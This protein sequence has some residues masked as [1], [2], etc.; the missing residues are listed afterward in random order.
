[1][2]RRAFAALSVAT[3]TA[4][5]LVV[6]PALA[7]P[8]TVPDHMQGYT[9]L[10]PGTDTS[11]AH[12]A[13][14]VAMYAALA[15]DPEVTVDELDD[16]FHSFAFGPD[17]IEREY[18][19]PGRTDVTIYRDSLGV[20]HVYSDSD[21]GAAY[22]LGYVS[23]EDRL[24]QM[25][26]LRHAGLGRLSEFLGASTTTFDRVTRRDTYST[27][28]LTKML[29]RLDDRF[30]PD[31]ALVQEM[32]QAYSDGVNARVAEIDAGAITKPIEY[33]VQRVEPET[34]RP[35]DSLAAAI[36]QIRAF[37][38]GGGQEME[39][40][41]A[42]QAL[43]AALGNDLGRGVFDDLYYRNDPDA[44]TSIPDSVGAFP[45]QDLGPVDAKAVAI[46]D[47]PAKVVDRIRAGRRA[48]ER[49]LTRYGLSS[50]ASHFVAVDPAHSDTGNPLQWGGPQ[51]GYSVPGPFMEIDVHS[52]SID[53][54][55]MAL[56][57]PRSS[58]RSAA[59]R[60]ERGL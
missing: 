58:R 53:S 20:P 26:V 44:P 8:P 25:D 13:D 46:P 42:L 10:P 4:A 52:P 41:A 17:T 14:Q 55:G 15:D 38:S 30:G 36:L 60:T 7:A 31:G 51:V 9:I 48:V 33:F 11:L 43:Q 45:S 3:L 34:W 47:D 16:Y 2:F 35:I 37:G 57:G 40:A 21:A 54:R 1:M 56:P 6:P 23:A 24:W 28:Q 59:P 32:L 39:N 50:P 49:T 27:E 22:A 18:M 5:L 19:P 12:T 29:N